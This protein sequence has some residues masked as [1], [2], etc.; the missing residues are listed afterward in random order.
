MV[1]KRVG[2]T[3]CLRGKRLDVNVVGGDVVGDPQGCH[4]M[5][6]PGR[7]EIAQRAEIGVFRWCLVMCHLF[8]LLIGFLMAALGERPEV[9]HVPD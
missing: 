8:F 5:D 7:A 9:S 4:H 6:A 1:T 2:V 3:F